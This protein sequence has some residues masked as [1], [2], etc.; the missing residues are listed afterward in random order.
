MKIYEF[1]ITGMSCAACSAAVERV[2]RRLPGV[3]S[4][5]VNLATERLRVRGEQIHIEDLQERI[6]KAG[7]TA[8]PI[9]DRDQ[10]AKLDE[11]QQKRQARLQLIRL[12]VALVFGLLLMYVGM[13]SMMGL[14]S[15]ISM[16]ERPIL[17]TLLQIVLLL[18]I[19]FVG[20]QFYVR[21]FRNA[22]RLHPNMD[23]LIA[24]GTSAAILYSLVSFV[25]VL[26]GDIGAVHEMYWESAGTIVALVMLGKFFES[27]SKRKTTESIRTLMQLAPDHANLITED[28]TIKHIPVSDLMIGDRLLVHPG[29]R[30]PTDGKLES[31]TASVDE[32]MLTGESMPVEKL[33]GDMLTGGSINGASSFTMTAVRV[34]EDTSLSQMIRLV[35][36]AQI[37]K[38]PVSRLADK[39]SGIFVPVVLGIAIVTAIV[40]LCVGQSVSFAL[41]AFI[42]VLVIACPCALGLATPT[43]IMVGTG[44][45]AKQGV[46]IKSGEALEHAHAL[47][48]L[49][50]DKTGTITVGKPMVT[51]VLPYNIGES[52][53]LEL[54]AAGEQNSE[55]PLGK[56]IVSYCTERGMQLLPCTAFTAI[57]GRGASATVEGHQLYMGNETYMQ[58]C[59]IAI[60]VDISSLA[61]QGKT[62]M[63][64]AIDNCFA[65]V[66]AVADTLKPD[67]KE[68]IAKLSGLGIRTVMV[69]GDHALT[70][71]AIAKDAGI[72]EVYSQALPA[73]K[74]DIIRE[75]QAESLSVGMVGDGINDAI[76]LSTADV[77]FAIGT[78]TDV[79]IASADIV[80]M[81]GRL[82]SVCEAIEVSR[83]TMRII[84][85]NLF[86]AFFYNMIGIP[87]A[88][89]V[90]YAFGGPLLSPMIAAL[91]MSFSSVTVLT[92]ALRLKKIRF[93]L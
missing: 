23:T 2:T 19:L 60:P 58:E 57:S 15:P 64:L 73:K 79:A 41:T 6:Q 7:F 62:P 4:C 75:L 33:C 39:I 70:A 45:A 16:T 20:R 52:T 18:P 67:A 17:F 21:G 56:A 40:W 11:L 31:E 61:L 3:E 38:A 42:S 53:F 71:Q 29:E 5:S 43:A 9:V 82:H 76:A 87:V 54:F 46:L 84:R 78:G 8:T 91:A 68:S 55:H 72:D 50:L 92:N 81:R 88:A 13:G 93:E 26:R 36:D 85:Q 12:C 74:A 69:T 89:G 90:L 1:K 35:E 34:G 59:G 32:S 83:A 27:R 30:I 28:G 48:A 37:S 65:G 44:R 66:I 49:V 14:P 80:L 25:R 10:Q 22:I 47:K 77:G 86:W 24:L 63:L 51:D